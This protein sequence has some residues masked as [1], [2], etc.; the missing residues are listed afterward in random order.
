MFWAETQ[1]EMVARMTARV[2]KERR[3]GFTESENILQRRKCSCTGKTVEVGGPDLIQV[4]TVIGLGRIK[5]ANTTEGEWRTCWS[6]SS[7]T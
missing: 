2:E 5:R 6:A 4:A 3:V 1:R 7:W